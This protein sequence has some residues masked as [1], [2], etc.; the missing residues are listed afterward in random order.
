MGLE[1]SPMFI[2]GMVSSL[3]YSARP[4]GA[5]CAAERSGS[6]GT[7]LGRR[8]GSKK[9]PCMLINEFMRTI[10]ALNQSRQEKSGG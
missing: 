3:P 9:D 7:A 4:T 2:I 8:G 6:V 5:R 1:G 10:E